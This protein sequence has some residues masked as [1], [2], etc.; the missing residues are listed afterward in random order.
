V[1][2]HI[3][4]EWG[5]NGTT[6]GQRVK[7]GTTHHSNRHRERKVR[8]RS[9]DAE[10]R[11]DSERTGKDETKHRHLGNEI[12]NASIDRRVSLFYWVCMCVE[13]E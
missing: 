3:Q 12:K 5:Q 4:I 10:N 9:A 13:M 8:S 7:E 6:N 1:A 11:S 2:K